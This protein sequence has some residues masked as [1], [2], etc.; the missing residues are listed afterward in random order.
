LLVTIAVVSSR[1][2]VAAAVFG[3][4]IEW[5][6]P[7]F[8]LFFAIFL[9]VLT[10]AGQTNEKAVQISLEVPV[11]LQNAN[12][13]DVLV[14]RFSREVT[15]DDRLVFDRL[16]GPSA[17]LAW[18]RTENRSAVGAYDNI[19]SRGTAMFAVMGLDSMRIA[20]VE[21]LPLDSWED[22]WLQWAGRLIAGAVGNPEEQHL[23]LVSGSYS[24]IRSSWESASKDTILQWGVR[25]WNTYPYLYI[26][27]HAGRFEGHPLFTLEARAG[28][29]LFDAPRIEGRLT[30]QLPASFCIAGAVAFDPSRITERGGGAPVF[31]ATLEKILRPHTPAS[32]AILFA[33][34]RS[35]VNTAF[36]TPRRENMLLAG[37]STGW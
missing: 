20:A 18:M 2:S 4:R 34:Y 7:A 24:A 25:P 36:F 29:R 28:Y 22:G 21:A 14:D 19:N 30:T 33:G 9:P 3:V 10:D 23:S 32:A 13:L 1:L 16:V 37:L 31:A 11:T 26:L 27:T 15:S 35:S 6:S 17:R 5:W 8:T 12:A